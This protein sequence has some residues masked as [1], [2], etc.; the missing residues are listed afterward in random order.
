[1][2][3]SIPRVL[4]IQSHVVR[5][6]VGNKSA[7]FPLQLLGLNVDAVNSVQFS[8]HTGYAGGFRGEVLQGDQLWA[9]LEGLEANNLLRGYSHVLTGYIGSESML[10]MVV[11]VLEKLR[12]HNPSLT[13]VCDPVMGD[14]GNMYVPQELVKVYRETVV[15]FASVLTPNQFEAEL[16]TGQA[17]HSRED[18]IKACDILHQNG[19]HT[20]ILT[21]LD[22]EPRD[23]LSLIASTTLLQVHCLSY[24]TRSILNSKKCVGH[25]GSHI[26]TEF[27][28]ATS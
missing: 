23:S 6:V 11:R 14:N 20:V 19:P 21:S 25:E 3:M 8:N 17:I 7:V 26:C 5:G 9:L 24:S 15:G 1:M 16:L 28:R 10:L 4:S 12:E 22:L 2:A 27:Q 18:A 13:Y